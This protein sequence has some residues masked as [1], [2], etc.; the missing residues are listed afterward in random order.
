MRVSSLKYF[1]LF[2]C[3]SAPPHESC[4][5]SALLAPSGG[6]DTAALQK[7]LSIAETVTVN[8]TLKISGTVTP[9]NGSGVAGAGGGGTILWTGPANTGTTY[10]IKFAGNGFTSTGVTYNGA[11]LNIDGASN[12]VFS[13]ANTIENIPGGTPNGIYFGSLTNSKIDGIQFS[14]IA[15]IGAIFGYNASGCHFD[16]N[17]FGS[18]TVEAIHI[19][20]NNAS[21]NCTVSNNDIS[22]FSR[23]GIELQGDPQGLTVANNYVH[24]PAAAASHI[25]MSIATGGETTRTPPDNATGV[26]IRGNACTAPPPPLLIANP[27]VNYCML[28]AMGNGTQVIGNYFAGGG[29]GGLVTDNPNM[30]WSN[31]QCHAVAA[32]VPYTQEQANPAIGSFNAVTQAGNTSDNVWTGVLPAAIAAAVGPSAAAAAAPALQ[33]AQAAA[34]S[35]KLVNNGD[36]SLSATWNDPTAGAIQPALSIAPA[37]GAASMALQ[38]GPLAAGATSARIAN[39]PANWLVTLTVAYPAPAAN[40]TGSASIQVTGGPA[41]VN[42]STWSPALSPTPATQPAPASAPAKM[43]THTITVYSDGSLAI[44]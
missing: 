44:H 37:N 42:N 20:W 18:G 29:W 34:V 22:G 4:L 35:V 14:N 15:A 9:A 39:I 10:A 32:G 25:W 43:V 26:I 5:A 6:D 28:E 31:N 36:G 17:T 19:L 21:G 8:G 11:G 41:P 3:V 33:P 16:G 2:L 40:I 27:Q 38:L 1:I 13:G 7:A 30:T 23:F 12:V 24:D